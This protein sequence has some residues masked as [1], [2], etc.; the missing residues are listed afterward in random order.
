M[1]PRVECVR[2]G[3]WALGLDC[4]Q[5]GEVWLGIDG[6]VHVDSVMLARPLGKKTA[7]CGPKL[8]VLKRTCL[9]ALSPR[10]G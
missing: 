9:G 3:L 1:V 2:C 6:V 7:G 10:F 8:P 5:A 4:W